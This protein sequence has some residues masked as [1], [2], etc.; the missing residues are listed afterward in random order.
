MEVGT[1]VREM[2][3]SF[4][5]RNISIGILFH[6]KVYFGVGVAVGVYSYMEVDTDVRL[7][8]LPLFGLEIYLSVFFFILKYVKPSPAVYN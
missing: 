8:W 5:P 6:P 1:D 4:R 7:K 3:P 2:V